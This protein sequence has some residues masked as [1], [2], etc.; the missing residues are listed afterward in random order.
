MPELES[1]ASPL[2][3]ECD[4]ED[5]L[6]D[7]LEV[8]RLQDPVPLL[9]VRGEEILGTIGLEAIVSSFDALDQTSIRDVMRP[10][11]EIDLGERIERGADVMRRSTA[12]AAIV[13]A[14]DGGIF[15]RSS[16]PVGMVSAAH[17]LGAIAKN[18]ID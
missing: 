4:P 8:L 9:V 12:E 5:T 6:A 1:I 7:I 10:A 3:A 18:V 17:V 2:G 11:P 16:A 15:S 14:P 13:T